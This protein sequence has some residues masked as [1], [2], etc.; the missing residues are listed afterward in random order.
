MGPSSLNS[1]PDAD[2]GI[3]SWTKIQFVQ[4]TDLRSR[5]NELTPLFFACQYPCAG[6]VNMKSRV[7]AFFY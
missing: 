4:A 6:K 3:N 5:V 1:K 7:A 2:K